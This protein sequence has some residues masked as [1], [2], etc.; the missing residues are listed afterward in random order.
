MTWL[1][2]NER[3]LIAVAL[4]HRLDNGAMLVPH[5]RGQAGMPQHLSHR[6]AQML[7]VEPHRLHDHDIPGQ[8]I[9]PGVERHVGADRGP[10]LLLHRFHALRE[11]DLS[12]REIGRR[13]S[14]RGEAHRQRLDR[15]A[16][17][18]DRLEQRRIE[19]R[20]AQ[21]AA[22]AFAQKAL[23]LQDQQR[24]MDRLARHIEPLRDVGLRQPLARLE[25]AVADRV[26]DHGIGLIHQR[27]RTDKRF[28]V[29][30]P[31]AAVSVSGALPRLRYTVYDNR[32]TI[33]NC[34]REGR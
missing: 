8:I 1:A 4:G 2:I 23:R 19:R 21:T 17:L 14:R 31:Q 5:A 15:R 3:R 27:C 12:A 25:R 16:E 13:H 11:Q 32:V 30:T 18:I 29:S 20:N 7:P 28:Q 9:D 34:Y 10:A 26:E 33:R 24:V 6:A 22:A